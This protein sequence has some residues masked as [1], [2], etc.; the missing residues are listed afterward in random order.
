MK[1]LTINGVDFEVK[2]PR[3]NTVTI[4]EAYSYLNRYKHRDLWSC[5]SKPSEA[6]TS[7]YSQWLKWYTDV[8]NT[9]TEFCI[10]GYNSMC[11]SLGALYTDIK[12]NTHYL[13][14]ITK[15]HNVATVLTID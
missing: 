3:K 11:F 6:K 4:F 9:L 5:Y 10:T 2:T 7:I 1:T 15:A 8:D 12:T 13:L 14:S